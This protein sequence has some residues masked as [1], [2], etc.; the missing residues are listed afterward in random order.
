[1]K[2]ITLTNHSYYFLQLLFGLM[3]LL[4]GCGTSKPYTTGTIKT[5]DP[6]T[7][8]IDQ[9]GEAASYQYWDRIDNTILHQIEKPLDLNRVFRFAGKTLGI[10]GAKQADNINRLDEA[11]KSSWYTFRHYYNPMTPDELARGPNTTHPDTSGNWTIFS[12][13]LEGMNPGFFAEDSEGNRFLIKFDGP[14]YPELTTSAEVISTKIF[15]ASGYYVPESTITYFDPDRVEVGDGVMIEENCKEQQMT[16]DDFRGI[17]SNATRNEKGQVRALASKF[18]DGV[19]LGPWNFEGTRSDDPNDRVDHEHRREIRGMRVISSWLNDTD[20]RDANTM[21]LYT[22]QGYIR[23]L[24]QDFGNTL[25]ANG[26]SIHYPIYGQAYLVDPRYMLVSGLSLGLKVHPWEEI[27]VENYIPD[28]SVGYFRSETFLPGDWVPVH[29]IPAFENMTLR[30]AFWGA[31][32]VMS[33][34]DEDIRAIVETGELSNKSAEEYLVQTLIERRNMI[35]G[36]WFSKINPIDK[37]SAERQ[38]DQLTLKF[39]D[40]GSETGIFDSEST[41]YIYTLKTTDGTTYAVNRSSDD[42]S[43]QDVVPS[44]DQDDTLVLHYQI[45]TIRDDVNT[46]ERNVDVYVVEDDN[47][48]RIGGMH[49]EE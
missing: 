8:A 2:S 25:G 33:F 16:Q 47:G 34:S 48:I 32:H 38:G 7:S 17:I 15:Y 14:N 42:S 20:R 26:A 43:L 3:V 11:P 5:F 39:T 35:G 12:A 1:M 44:P 45:K 23:H 31:K 40:L 27:D 46:P 18:V 6:D 9:P 10:S 49:R 28:P 4:S 29:P 13:K 22:D 24:V 21:S 30:D 37:F 19:P 41:R 36:Y